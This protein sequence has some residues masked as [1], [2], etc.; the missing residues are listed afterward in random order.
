MDDSSVLPSAGAEV[1][2][3]RG[4]HDGW[5]RARRRGVGPRHGRRTVRPPDDS[6]CGEVEKDER[7]SGKM[8]ANASWDTSGLPRLTLAIAGGGR[9]TGQMR[10]SSRR[11]RREHAQQQG[12]KG[13]ASVL[14]QRTVAASG[15][16][17]GR[18]RAPPARQMQGRGGIEDGL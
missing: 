11:R 13:G 8:S 17:R 10:R 12:G 15:P 16:A 9:Y 6:S 2:D 7:L 1:G 14:R 5:L 4:G 3:G 18:G